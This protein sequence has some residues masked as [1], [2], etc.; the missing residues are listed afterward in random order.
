MREPYRAG[1]TTFEASTRGRGLP[2]RLAPRLAA[3][4]RL[5]PVSSAYFSAAAFSPA[6]RPKIRHSPRL[7]P[8]W[9]WNA[10]MLPNSP[11]P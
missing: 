11:A 7:Q 2:A 5:P 6:M 10:L 9:Y 3:S 4:A 1:V 8:P